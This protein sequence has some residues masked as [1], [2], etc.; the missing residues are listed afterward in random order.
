MK[1]ITTTK[2]PLTQ[3][4]QRAVKAEW[5]QLKYDKVGH[6]ILMVTVVGAVAWSVGLS[7]LLAGYSSEDANPSERAAV[8]GVFQLAILGLFFWVARNLLREESTKFVQL[9]LLSLPSRPVI[10]AA[11]WLCLVVVGACVMLAAT[12]LSSGATLGT[13]ALVGR[14][15]HQFVGDSAGSYVILAGNTILISVVTVS[16]AVAVSIV[17]NNLSAAV[18]VL[19]AW[20]LVVEG[21]IDGSD[22]STKFFYSLLPFKNATRLFEQADPAKFLWGEPVSILYSLSVTIALAA[23]VIF[24]NKGKIDRTGRVK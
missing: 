5:L 21:M 3:S 9:K 20:I 13:V 2:L 18:T 12:V 8:S 23:F 22:P 11:K 24:F 10:W 14:D 6:I 4:I 19:V 7:A 1:E 16:F 17:A 15:W